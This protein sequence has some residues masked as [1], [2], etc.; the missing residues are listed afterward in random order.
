[1]MGVAWGEEEEAEPGGGSRSCKPCPQKGSEGFDRLCLTAGAV[2]KPPPTGPGDGGGGEGEGGG[3][4]LHVDGGGIKVDVD[5]C[6]L[7]DLCGRHGDCINTPDGKSQ[8]KKI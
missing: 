8:K 6:R 4:G 5:E 2:V 3:G 1:M 7:L